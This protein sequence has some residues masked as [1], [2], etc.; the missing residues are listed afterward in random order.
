MQHMRLI[1]W[2]EY[3]LCLY[4]IT[5][6]WKVGNIQLWEC[7]LELEILRLSIGKLVVE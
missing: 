7:D 2:S 6:G 1:F 3:I 4:N 5:V